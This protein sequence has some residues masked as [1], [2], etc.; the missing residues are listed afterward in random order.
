MQQGSSSTAGASGAATATLTDEQIL[1]LEPVPDPALVAQGASRGALHAAGREGPEAL[2]GESLSG[3]P[4]TQNPQGPGDPNPTAGRPELQSAADPAWLT[5]LE[6]QPEGGREAAAEARQWRDTARDI[7][8][9]DAAY[10]GADPAARGDLAARLYTSDPAAFRAMLAEGARMLSERDPQALADLARQLGAPVNG[11]GAGFP[12][13][14]VS[15]AASGRDLGSLPVASHE[16]Q[17]PQPSLAKAG[18]QAPATHGAPGY[19][20]SDPHSAP[21][22]ADAYRSFE[23]ATN[24]EVSRRMRDSIDRTLASTLPQG[25]AEGARRRIGE[26]IFDEM[27][28][29]L[30]ADRDL[31]RQ[32]SELLRGWRFDSGTRQQV[33]G[34]VAGRARAVLPEVARRVVGEWTSSVLASDRARTARMDAAASRRDI[35]G[36][37]LPEPV[38]VGA[39]RPRDLDYARLSDEQILEL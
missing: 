23:A 26:D 4:T 28:A 20:S 3:V 21:F 18:L 35:T 27:H 22:P 6:A 15:D 39:L 24:D 11:P 32:V 9:L 29:T 37:R 16:N 12:V 17:N 19:N 10:F 38:P 8:S 1:G 2:D 31:T 13:A 33:A 34:L 30:A 14:Q 7:A 25:I 36:G 5:A